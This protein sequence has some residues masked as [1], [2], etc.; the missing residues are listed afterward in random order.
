MLMN[1]LKSL[2]ILSI[3]GIIGLAGCSSYSVKR[4]SLDTSGNVTSRW[5][6][7]DARATAKK[8]IDKALTAPWL[9]RFTDSNN[10]RPVVEIGEIINRSDQ[11]INTR[12]FMN[13][14]QDALIDSGKVVFVTASEAH[15][16]QASYERYY[17][18][19]HSRA[20]TLHPPGRQ[21]GADILFTGSINSFGATRG[22]KTV[23]YYETHLKAIDLRTNEIV[24]ASQYQVKKIAEE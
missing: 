10:R 15:R 23:R 19:R 5:T 2:G 4:V 9:S 7:T 14:F 6:D 13:H 3:A 24:W 20:S 12:L 8:M 17:Q 22:E 16:N 21:M 1:K 11:A 18:M